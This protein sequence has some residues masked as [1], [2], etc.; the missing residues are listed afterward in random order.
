M[1][2]SSN[3]AATSR[4][5]T[6]HFLITWDDGSSK[7]SLG[8]SSNDDPP[9]DKQEKQR[10]TSSSKVTFG[11]DKKT[12]GTID[13]S[14]ELKRA[15]SRLV[16]PR[17]HL[18]AHAFSYLA[19]MCSDRWMKNEDPDDL[20]TSASSPIVLLP[21]TNSPDH[22][23][24]VWLRYNADAVL[25]PLIQRS[26]EISANS[27]RGNDGTVVL[28][29]GLEFEDAVRFLDYYGIL[30][31][32][33]DPM[34]K[35]C[36]PRNGPAAVY[37][38]S[39]MYM[40]ELEMVGQFRDA[41]VEYIA[42]HPRRETMFVFAKADDDAEIIEGIWNLSRQGL[43]VALSFRTAK[44]W[45]KESPLEKESVESITEDCA[46]QDRLISVLE[47]EDRLEA[48][49]IRDVNLW[50]HEVDEESSLPG[51]CLRVVVRENKL[52]EEDYE[53]GHPVFLETFYDDEENRKIYGDRHVLEVKIPQA[54]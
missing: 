12:S 26:Y 41:I 51:S 1:A 46:L 8:L 32:M 54:L 24:S 6:V 42:C 22:I 25:V 40:R 19:A 7:E 49:F 14:A 29:F 50:G 48:K 23:R 31:K 38:R 37:L 17:A 39:K 13:N 18:Q 36:V 11:S 53:H 15:P 30:P 3:V 16:I 43:M 52:T 4:S 47:D 2:E 27:G 34:E 20:G 35:V 28:P 45:C 21:L 33:D 44:N 5:E 10:G 9:S